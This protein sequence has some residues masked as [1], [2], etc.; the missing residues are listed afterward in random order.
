MTRENTPIV[1][2]DLEVEEIEKSRKPGGCV[3][4]SSTSLLCTCPCKETTT[5]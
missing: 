2:L 5:V 1:S 4:S 3:T